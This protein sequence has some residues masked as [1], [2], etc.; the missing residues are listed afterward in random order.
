VLVYCT[1]YADIKLIMQHLL[2][3]HRGFLISN[4]AMILWVRRKD[5]IKEMRLSYSLHGCCKILLTVSLDQ[6]TQNID[7]E[8]NDHLKNL[9]VRKLPNRYQIV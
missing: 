2:L 5:Q 8:S 9:Y 7:F 4:N 6:A 3:G 1:V